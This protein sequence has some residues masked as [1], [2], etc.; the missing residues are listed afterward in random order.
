[1]KTLAILGAG[2]SGLAV[3][4]EFLKKNWTVHLYDPS[5]I[6]GG[7]SGVSAGL[8]H[9]FT[10]LRAKLAPDGYEGMQATLELLKVASEAMASPVSQKTEMLRL[11]V[12]AEMEADFQRCAAKH[13]KVRWLS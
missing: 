9:P 8:L 11:A 10:G 7:A 4:W 13:E 2:F 12:N 6:G 3:A 5:G 1:M